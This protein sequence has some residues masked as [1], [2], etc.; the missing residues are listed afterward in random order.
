LTRTFINKLFDVVGYA[1]KKTVRKK[2]KKHIYTALH[3]GI[4]CAM[5]GNHVKSDI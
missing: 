5:D 1:A 4:V 2:R 3:G